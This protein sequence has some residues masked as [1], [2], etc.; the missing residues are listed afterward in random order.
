VSSNKEHDEG[1]LQEVVE[2]E[3][4]SYTGCCVDVL[5][6]FGEEVPHICNLEEEECQPTTHQ[7][8]FCKT[9]GGTDQ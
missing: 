3:M 8:T 2:D 4:A 6:L 5:G 1:E 9:N 7:Y